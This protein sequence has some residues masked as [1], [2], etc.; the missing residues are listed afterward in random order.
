M[1]FVTSILPVPSKLGFAVPDY[2]LVPR[3][4]KTKLFVLQQQ[5]ISVIKCLNLKPKINKM[6]KVVE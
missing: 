5:R 2:L 4:K 1:I 3:V 6:R